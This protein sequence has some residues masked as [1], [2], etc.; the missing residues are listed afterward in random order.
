VHGDP[1]NPRSDDAAVETAVEVARLDRCAVPGGEDQAVVNPAISRT[2]AVRIL[3]FHANLE[4]RHAQLGQWQW[5]LGCLGLDLA[6][7][8]LAAD[9]LELLTDVQ[10]CGVQVDELP[11]ESEYLAFALAQDQDQDKG[12]VQGLARVP[13]RFQEPAGII[14]RPSTRLPAPAL[15]TSGELD[16]I[17]RISANA[18]FH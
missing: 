10:L 3:L 8:K 1:G 16:G 2:L 18:D 12:G 7:E 14:D 5:C 4:R 17:Y 6:A 9:P 11:G 15:T 13:G